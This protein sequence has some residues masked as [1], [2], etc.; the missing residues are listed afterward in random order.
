[1]RADVPMPMSSA[2]EDERTALGQTRRERLRD[3]LFSSD[4]GLSLDD[5]EKLLEARRSTVIAAREHLR[6]SFKH[7]DATLL[8]V[9]PSC[10]QCG[11]VFRL[12]SPKAPSRCPQCKSRALSM[13][14]FKATAEA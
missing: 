4:D 11:F 3:L 13:P 7:Q 6:L 5:I 8:M 9:P 14:I 1:M 10:T 2:A 12:E